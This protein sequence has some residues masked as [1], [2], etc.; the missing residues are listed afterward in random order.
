MAQAKAKKIEKKTTKLTAKAGLSANVYGKDG[1]V[2][3]K[4]TIPL[5]IFHA[6]INPPLMV[7][8][9][10]VYLA[11]QRV[12]SAHTKTRAEVRGSTRKI[13]RQKGTGRARHGAITAPIFVGGGIALGPRHRDFSLK[14]PTQMK[15]KALFSALT[16]K[17]QDN[18]V[19]ILDNLELSGKTKEIAKVLSQLKD[20]KGNALIVFPKENKN[21]ERAARNIKNVTCVSADSINTYEVLKNSY[22]VMVKD[23]VKVLEDTFLKKAGN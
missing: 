18:K 5:E 1:K 19:I 16:T 9:I 6:L 15:R 20:V 10:R 14:M 2:V 12:G 8:A 13:Y 11:N 22:V 7:Q 23:S 17:Y 21:I 4:V 3:G